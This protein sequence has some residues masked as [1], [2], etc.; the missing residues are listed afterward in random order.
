[1]GRAEIAGDEQVKAVTIYTTQWCPFCIRAKR[2]LDRKN[3]A[4]N[5]MP[6]DGDAPLRAKMAAMAGATS[7]PQI[8]IG[9]QHVGG[10][11]EL[12]SLE[13]QQR[14]DSMLQAE[15]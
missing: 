5:E 4:F 6:V 1:M 8:W 2:L 13:R 3:I 7:V 12:Y 14:L 10:C 15:A 9:D 11:D